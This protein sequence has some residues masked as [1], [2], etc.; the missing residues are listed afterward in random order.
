[1]SKGLFQD[2][3]GCNLF[4]KYLRMPAMPGTWVTAVNRTEQFLSSLGLLVS[5]VGNQ[6]LREEKKAVSFFLYSRAEWEYEKLG[7][8]ALERGKKN[9]S[10]LVHSGCHSKIPQTGGLSH[11]L[12][13]SVLEAGIPNQGAIRFGVW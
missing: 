5:L 3:M 12:I 13:F 10:V 1:M 11:K 6:E 9:S 4:N 8:F 7:C 2:G